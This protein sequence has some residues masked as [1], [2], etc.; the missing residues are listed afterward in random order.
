MIRDSA[1]GGRPPTDRR[2]FRAAWPVL[3][4]RDPLA[5]LAAL[6]DLATFDCRSELRNIQA[7]MPIT[8]LSRLEA[9]LDAL[10]KHEGGGGTAS[11]QFSRLVA[12]GKLEQAET[13]RKLRF[14]EDGTLRV[15]APW[16]G[17]GA[18]IGFSCKRL[19]LTAAG[20][21]GTIRPGNRRS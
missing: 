11:S 18:M 5:P 13:R 21:C 20:F 1:G 6:R 8:A 12:M 10:L 14:N 16:S 19:Q 7:P 2:K 17:D 15:E 4:R 9:K 3:D